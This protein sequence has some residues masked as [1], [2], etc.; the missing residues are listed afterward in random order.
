ME[1]LCPICGNILTKED[2][3][4]VCEKNHSFDI[5]WQ[6]HVNLLPVQNKRSLNPG[7]T[8][9]Q[10]VSRRAF[11]DG[12]FYF[13]SGAKP[14]CRYFCFFN[15]NPPEMWAEQGACITNGDV[16]FVVVMNYKLEQYGIDCSKYVL[17]DEYTHAFTKDTSYTYYLYQKIT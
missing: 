7:D 6:G 2:K 13:A 12:G 11:L 1:L 8:A 16:D 3:R 4:Y 9:E 10:V 5:A 17:V 14:V 15:I